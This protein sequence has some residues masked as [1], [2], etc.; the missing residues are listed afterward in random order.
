[1]DVDRSKKK[2]RQRAI[3]YNNLAKAERAKLEKQ[4]ISAEHLDM[5]VDA[6]VAEE[7]ERV[8]A[9]RAAASGGAGGAGAAPAKTAPRRRSARKAAQDKSGDVEM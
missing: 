4:G 3:R 8:E 2:Q 6:A 1:M 5:V 7:V 9:A